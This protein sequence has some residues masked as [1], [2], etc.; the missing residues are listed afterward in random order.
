MPRFLKWFLMALVIIGVGY[1][2]AEWIMKREIVDFLNRKVPNHIDLSYDN[3]SINLLKGNLEF[4]KV[5]VVSLG[6]Q[7]SSC[8]IKVS[9]D[10]LSINGF[11][12]W[13]IL[14]QKSVFLKTLTLSNPHLVFKT[15]PNNKEDKD[16]P[17]SNPINL[18]KQIFV[19]ELIFDSGKVEIL[20]SNDDTELLYVN[21]IDLNLK[22][23]STDNEVIKNYVP[24][25]F[26]NYKIS[27]KDMKAPLGKFEVLKMGSMTLDDSTIE[28]NAISL[29]TALSKSELSKEIKYQRD[30]ISLFIPEIKV[31]DHRY[32]MNADSL[33]VNF[34]SL[35]LIT[36]K[37]EIYRDKSR[38]ESLK[39]RPLY[40]E[41]MRKLPFKINID[42]VL[43]KKAF[44]RYEE[45]I[46]NGVQ[47]GA[48]N[49]EN[50]DAS[51]A[52]FSN[53]AATKENLKIKLNANLM[54]VG[55]FKLNWEFDVQDPNE[56]FII[57]GSLFNLDTESLNDFL[58][59][60][61][62]TKTSGTIDELYFTISGDDHT[63][64]GDIKMKYEDFK[65]Q[66]MN[67]ERSGV[68]KVLS[69]VGNLFISDGSKADVDG[70]RY[71]DIATERA[72]NKSFFNYLWINLQDGLV[73]VLTGNGKKN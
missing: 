53:L 61:L 18:L 1:V 14:F 67:K 58:V 73:H 52:N 20:S 19:G 63:A 57:K 31:T 64:T 69:F 28:I 56:A 25:E 68:K 13:K 10:A 48:L 5:T 7:T 37:L 36:P 42:S 27:I 39:R 34:E 2:A 40:A 71:G 35:S 26:S 45:D 70:Y 3:L 60:N 17:K 33:N 47:A 6:R 41:L 15:C 22:N 29:A 62:R 12:Y 38:L 49:F 51:I 9:A 8:E 55:N 54:G 30:H 46:P 23:V 11:S 50:L 4:E 65:F 72:M 44:I 16:A 43:I 66:V 59:P 21:A 24:F 32:K